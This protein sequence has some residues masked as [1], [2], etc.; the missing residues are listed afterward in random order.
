MINSIHAES[1]RPDFVVKDIFS[2]R[3]SSLLILGGGGQRGA[4]GGGGLTALEKMHL[5]SA[6]K[7]VIGVS[8]G[9]PSG[10]YFLA[11]QAEI[12]TTLYSQENID[13]GYFINLRREKVM[14]V[15]YVCN[16]FE[17]GNLKEE[18]KI[19]TEKFFE[20]KSTIFYAVTD[21]ETGVGELL[22]SK[23]IPNVFVGIKASCA[24]P[25]IYGKEIEIEIDGKKKKF[26]D[27]SVA[28]PMPIRLAFDIAIPTSVVIFA[29]RHKISRPTLLS[30]LINKYVSMLVKENLSEDILKSEERFLEE[31]KFLKKSKVP[32]IIFWTDESIGPLEQNPEKIILAAK[33]FEDYVRNFIE[34]YR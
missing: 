34:K 25:E 8:T 11:G 3:G 19:N 31:L 9:A 23:I 32:Y 28:I 22:N 33:T 4:Y 1:Y 13:S 5:N 18:K 29:N 15:D 7:F 21:M 2:D 24:V 6:F 30:K 27:G 12:G 10:S 16:L 14:D 17:N 20:N 26:V